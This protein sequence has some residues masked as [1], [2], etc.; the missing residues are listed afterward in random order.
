M[1][2]KN[3]RKREKAI[4]AAMGTLRRHK[5]PALEAAERSRRTASHKTAGKPEPARERTYSSDPAPFFSETVVIS[6]TFSYSG[7]GFGFCRPDE[8]FAEE[9]PGDVFIPPRLTKGAMTGDRVTV[10]AFFTGMREDGS[11]GCEGEVLSV[12]SAASS[13]IGT[14]HTAGGVWWVEPD[15][16][17]WGV[18]VSVPRKDAENAGAREGWK[19]E[20]VPAGNPYFVRGLTSS[21]HGRSTR[22]ERAGSVTAPSCEVEGRVASVFG[23]GLTRD[24]NYAAILAGCGIRTAFPES[25]LEAAD[26][27]A[28]ETV[29]PASDPARIDLRDR[30]IFTIDGAGAKDLDDAISLERTER[31]WVL[32]VHIAD[33]SHYV[34]PGSPA[35]KEAA[36]RGTSVYFTDKVV[37]MLPESLS[38]GACS[39]NA[40]E[41]R[42]AMTAEVTLDAAGN[43]AGTRIFRSVIRSRVRGIYSEVNDIFENGETSPYAEKYASVLPM[44]REMHALYLLLAERSRERGVLELEDSEAVILLD[45]DGEPCEV[46]PAVRGD[47]ERLIEQ[48]MLQANMGVAETLTG[49]KLPCL[50]RTH[51]RPDREKLNAFAIFASN[52]GLDT[53]NIVPDSGERTGARHELPEDELI[54][55]LG[56]ILADAEERGMGPMISL[57]LLRSMMKAKYLPVPARHFGLGADLYCHFTSPIRR[58]PDLFVH[59]V[60]TAV[61]EKTGSPFLTAGM[62]VP[63]SAAAEFARMASDRAFTSSECEVRAMDAER[64]IE[65]LYLTLYMARHIGE[66]FRAV[67]SGVTRTG[68]FVRCDNLAEGFLP[69]ESWPGL[70]TDEEHLRAAV[71]GTTYTL[72]SPLDVILTEAD[73]GTRRISFVPVLSSPEEDG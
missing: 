19:V 41:D 66:R 72:G 45:E 17:R 29:D 69:A 57:M 65:D 50:Y 44:L 13:L 25:V 43:R 51:A 10:E 47:G 39:L 9:I 7:R 4:R 67:I 33:V 30:V 56:M 8:E 40:G 46:V 20:V 64:D 73:P 18:S 3:A 34:R 22:P 11:R 15:S 54:R 37:P 21:F 2:R 23:D 24:A 6:G 58:Y 38:N 26:L 1:P 60:I 68:L 31:G 14:L 61:L 55:R 49:L 71:H 63:V 48:F 27:S 53:R 16:K 62:N 70:R 59:S 52:L 36:L 35:E 42:Y 28:R 32:G 12:E 5:N